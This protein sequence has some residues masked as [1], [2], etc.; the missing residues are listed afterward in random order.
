MQTCRVRVPLKV[1]QG[2]KVYISKRK[3]GKNIYGPPR[4]Q[5]GG[6][7]PP[8]LIYRRVSDNFNLSQRVQV[9]LLRA[10]VQKK[11][12]G[13]GR[14]SVFSHTPP[15]VFLYP[16]FYPL[17]T[18]FLSVPHLYRSP[19]KPVTPRLFR[20]SFFIHPMMRVCSR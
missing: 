2:K 16:T 19:L 7:S 10:N 13:S 17:F 20:P 8:R 3:G 11:N 6:W 9:K 1:I 5:T 18:F 12:T 14:A 4:P 15:R